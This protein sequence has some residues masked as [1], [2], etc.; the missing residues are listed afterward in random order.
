MSSEQLEWIKTNYS[1]LWASMDGDFRGYLDDIIQYGDTEKEIIKSINEQLTQT[2]FD[3]VFDSFV[4]TLMDMDAS[5]K[6]FADS[7]EEYMRK[8]I[9]TSMFA[10]NYESALEEWYDAFAEANKKKEGITEDD[11][12]N[13]K[14]RWDG[15]VNSA[16]SDRET[17]EKIVGSSDPE[18]SR[19]ASQKGIATASQ[20][21]V[22]ENNGRLAVMQ[23]HTYNINENVNRMA[24]GID[25]IV[26]HTV[27]LS[28][29]TN[30]DKTMQSI[31]SM[32]D[33]SLTHLSN[34]DNHT[35]D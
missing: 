33:A 26:G 13:L 20:D 8:A 5:S 12:R 19:E 24:T 22:D 18:S 7:F 3:S 1:G 6:D 10:K 2:S 4:N 35:V 17:W 30:I 29:L 14:N 21:S 31:L 34:I 11:V 25:T 32:R 16:L 27:N 9:F 28:C 15:I 23:E